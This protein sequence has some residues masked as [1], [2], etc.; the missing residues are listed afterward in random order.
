MRWGYEIT[1]VQEWLNFL[2]KIYV[3][4]ANMYLI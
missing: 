4:I 3:Y 1:Y 2:V